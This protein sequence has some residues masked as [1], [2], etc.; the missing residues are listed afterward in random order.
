MHLTNWS[1]ENVVSEAVLVQR[2]LVGLDELVVDGGDGVAVVGGLQNCKTIH[3]V[4]WS[5]IQIN[6]QTVEYS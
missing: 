5:I 6:D 1:F 4:K 2:G 3:I